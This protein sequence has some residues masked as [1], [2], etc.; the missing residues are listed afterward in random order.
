MTTPERR[1]VPTRARREPPRFR[2]VTVHR[3]EH[4]SPRLVRVTFA[5]AELDGFAVEEPAASVR[6]LLPPPGTAELVVPTW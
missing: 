5:G 3:V 2:R 6:L 4:L 1:S